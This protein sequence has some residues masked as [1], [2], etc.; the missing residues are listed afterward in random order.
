[1]E[2][3]E[4]RIVDPQT[5]QPRRA[6]EVGEI[7]LRSPQIMQAYWNRPEDTA[8]SIDADG[9][10]HTGDAGYVDD[11]GYLY[12][13]DRVKDMIISGG[14]NIYP[15]EIENV[16]MSH[17]AVDD[18]AVIGVPSE[19]WG[20]TPKAIVIRREGS[21]ATAEELVAHCRRHLASYKAPTSVDFVETIPRNPSGKILK[22]ELREPFWKRHGRGVN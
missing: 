4:L 5:G 3:V 17:P 22:H 6:G 19:R 8:A 15:A 2:G 20:E 1:M 12:I 13:S 18:V 9:W 11:D 16:L 10:F 7:E 21:D 14:E